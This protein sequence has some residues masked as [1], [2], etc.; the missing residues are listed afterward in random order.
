MN[1]VTLGFRRIQ[2]IQRKT[3]EDMIK[4]NET[5]INP[6]LCGGAGGG[7]FNPPSLPCCISLN[8]SETIKDATQAFCSI[9][10]Q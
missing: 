1:C 5:T 9:Q 10:Y 4:Y 6:N 7:N 3:A 8:N 2:K